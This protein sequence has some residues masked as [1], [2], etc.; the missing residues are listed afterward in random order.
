MREEGTVAAL[1]LCTHS[2]N[3]M[4]CEQCEWFGRLSCAVD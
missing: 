1:L 4:K 2:E 3:A